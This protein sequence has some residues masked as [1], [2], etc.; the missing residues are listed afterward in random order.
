M[1]KRVATPRGTSKQR[2]VKTVGEHIE[3][4]K[5]LEA[6]DLLGLVKVEI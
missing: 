1:G 6:F 5:Y 4:E 3:V 2:V